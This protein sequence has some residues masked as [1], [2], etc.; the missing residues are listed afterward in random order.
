[1]KITVYELLGLVKDDKAPK[2]IKY[3]GK[4]Y[5]FK[6]IEEGNGYVFE[7]AFSKQWLVNRLEIDNVEHL[8]CE[9][10][11]IEEDKK[12]EKFYFSVYQ[13]EKLGGREI[14]E[15][16]ETKINELIDEINNL[17]EKVK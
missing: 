4:I 15:G 12:I 10:E 1:M 9:V 11:I 2:K 5:E 13:D 3:D 8:N 7:S 16:L 14:V 6:D 17:K